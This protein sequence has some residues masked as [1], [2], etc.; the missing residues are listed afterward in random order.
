MIQKNEFCY[1]YKAMTKD[2]NKRIYHRIIP[3]TTADNP[4]D[5]WNTVNK[6]AAGYLTKDQWFERA[7]KWSY[8]KGWILESTTGETEELIQC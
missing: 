6:N 4:N 3:D 8:N 2:P 5:K 1:L 7:S